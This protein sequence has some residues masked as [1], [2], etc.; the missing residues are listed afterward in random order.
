[1]SP[2]SPRLIEWANANRP[3]PSLDCVKGYV[4]DLLNQL[5]ATVTS[6]ARA[7][8]RNEERNFMLCDA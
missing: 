1:M 7:S 3:L 6:A 8:K 5:L 4:P 2:S